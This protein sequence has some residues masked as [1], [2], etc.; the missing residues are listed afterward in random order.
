ML[1]AVIP[2]NCLKY[3]Y[4]I[5]SVVGL[6]HNYDIAGYLLNILED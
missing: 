1:F 6:C 3:V 4:I 2:Q 5:S